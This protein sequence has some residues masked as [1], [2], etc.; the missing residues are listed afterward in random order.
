MLDRGSGSGILACRE[1]VRCWSVPPYVRHSIHLH[2]HHATFREHSLELLSQKLLPTPPPTL[3]SPATPYLDHVM[4]D[5][6]TGCI[7]LDLKY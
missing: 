3:D 2:V 6:L 4:S 1:Y 5:V 7:V